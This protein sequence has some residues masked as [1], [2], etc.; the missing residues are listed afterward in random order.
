MAIL[1]EN[2]IQELISE[3]NSFSIC[4]TCNHINNCTFNDRKKI[5]VWY[6][7]EFDAFQFLN[8]HTTSKSVISGN[9]VPVIAFDNK[10]KG[11]CSNCDQH[12]AC[13]YASTET[14]VWHCN[15]YK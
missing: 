2:E 15:E 13:S 7:N 12:Y 10:Y 4:Q 5:S 14:G 9:P 6:C 1:T 8:G 11:L 3:T